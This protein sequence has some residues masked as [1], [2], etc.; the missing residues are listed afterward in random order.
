MTLSIKLQYNAFILKFS[1]TKKKL[2]TPIKKLLTLFANIGIYE[3]LV[4]HRNTF[5]KTSRSKSCQ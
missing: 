3:V 5:N 4:R 2:K 1:A